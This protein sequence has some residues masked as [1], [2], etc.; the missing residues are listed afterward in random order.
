MGRFQGLTVLV[1]GATGG[2]GRRAAERFAAEGARLVLS[3]LEAGPLEELAALLGT[4]SV[5]LAGDITDESLS[6]LS[7]SLQSR[8]SGDWTLP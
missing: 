5:T 4:E 8:A 1:T 3:D 7:L 2:F 6:S